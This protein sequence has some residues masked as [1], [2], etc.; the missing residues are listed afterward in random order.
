MLRSHVL[1]GTREAGHD[2]ILTARSSDVLQGEAAFRP[3]APWSGS[4][5]R[6][7]QAPE[8]SAEDIFVGRPSFIHPAAAF[9]VDLN[10]PGTAHLVQGRPD[11]H[12]EYVE[13]TLEVRGSD[14]TWVPMTVVR[15]AD[16]SGGAPTVLSGY[17]AYGVSQERRYNPMMLRL[18]DRG[19]TF[20]VAHVRGGGENGASWHDAAR[21][22]EKPRSFDDFLAC[23]DELVRSGIADGDSIVAMGG[24]AGGLL[25]AASLNRRPDAFVGVVVDVPFVDPLT[26]MMMP[27]LPLTV[28]DRAEWGDPLADP[29]IARC[30][31]SYS[32]YHNVQSTSYPPVFAACG[33]RDSRVSPVEPLKWINELRHR[34]SGGPFVLAVRDAGHSG[35]SSM[36]DALHD[37]ALEYAWVSACLGVTPA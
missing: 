24:S 5:A 25:V 23:R 13:E 10:D 30:L 34:A 8:W 36:D 11:T 2:A 37:L 21:G 16:S 28:S 22:L 6:L 26:T 14:G 20:A 33:L 29:A 15:R 3:I 32:P 27:E 35:R 1:V 4:D 12:D 18:M 7:L 19:V 9:R 17:G 31:L